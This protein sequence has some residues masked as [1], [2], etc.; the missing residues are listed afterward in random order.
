MGIEFSGNAKMVNQ[1]VISIEEYGQ[2]LSRAPEG[3][4][5]MEAERETWNKNKAEG[6]KYV[7]FLVIQKGDGIE[8]RRAYHSTKEEAEADA[9]Q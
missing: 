7:T 8:Y 6:K 5:E 2:A 1:V 9:D 3:V 4:T